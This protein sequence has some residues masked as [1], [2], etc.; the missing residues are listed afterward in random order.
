MP[1]SREEF[2]KRMKE[3]REKA[4]KEK[5]ERKAAAQAAPETPQPI[6]EEAPP[7]RMTTPW[8]PARVLDIPER[9]K[10]PRFTYRF[11]NTQRD[12][13]ELKKLQEGWEF[14]H[15][16]AQKLNEMYY[17]GQKTLRDGTPIGST[18][19]VRELIVMRMPKEMAD[20]RNKFYADKANR[21]FTDYRGQL[22]NNITAEGAAAPIYGPGIEEEKA[23][24]RRN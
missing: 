8:K 21:A 14:D 22:K 24:V 7:K 1:V 18:H 13:N 16:L 9:L 10:D 5:E 12:G 20:S 15:K 3:G 6:E 19:K 11:V 17:G 4:K 23:F 2:K